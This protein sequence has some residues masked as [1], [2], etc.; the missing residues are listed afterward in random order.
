MNL[1][2]DLIRGQ[3]KEITGSLKEKWGKLSDNDLQSFEGNFEQLSG[4]LQKLYGY[5][6]ERASAEIDSTLE[7]FKNSDFARKMRGNAE[8]TVDD[9]KGKV[10]RMNEKVRTDKNTM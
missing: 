6:K 2:A 5:S 8:R 1:N 7:R 9:A 3:W 4:K 10:D